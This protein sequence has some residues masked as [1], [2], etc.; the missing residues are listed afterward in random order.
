MRNPLCL[1]AKLNAS[2]VLDQ[3]LRSGTLMQNS[4]FS[5]LFPWLCPGCN[6]LLPYPQVLCE[7]CS[8]SL[9]KIVQ[10]L[11]KRCGDP[12]PAHWR[13]DLCSECRRRSSGLTKI[14]S[15]YFY[16]NLAKTL[17]RDAKFARKAR[18][19]RF[20]SDEMYL[21][22]RN[23]FPS[24][25]DAVVPVPLHRSREWERTFN[26]A[27]RI[28][29]EVSKYWGIPLWRALRKV[30][31]TRSQSSLTESAR[32]KNLRGAF[33]CKPVPKIP[34]SIVLIDDV[35]TTGTTLRECARTLKRAGV[36]RV[37]GITVARAVK[38]F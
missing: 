9:K 6:L 11:C 33:V 4:I 19:L 12:F 31:K 10:P 3:M 20:F 29:V 30:E 36:R 34:R 32:R 27:E 17:I 18:I 37:Y 7:R 13:V 26:Q 25:V 35:V 1:F 38:L 14:R 24:S 22:A 23:E 8:A 5:L 28:A 2:F 16:E 21:L 15:V